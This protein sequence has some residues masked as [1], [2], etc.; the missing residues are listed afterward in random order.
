MHPHGLAY[1][2]ESEGALYADGT[3]GAAKKDDLVP[4]GGIHSYTWRVPERSGP[5]HGDASSVLWMY[6][7]HFV[8]GRDINTGLVGPIVITARGSAKPDGSPKDIDREFVTAFATFDETQSWFFEANLAKQKKTV[9]AGVKPSDPMFRAAFLNYSI[10]GLIEG[11]LPMLTMKEGEHVRWYMF[12]LDND[13]DVHTPHWHGQTAVSNHMRT[14]TIQL[15]PM[16]MAVADM[17]ADNPGTWLFHCHVNE[18]FE[19]GMNARFTVLPS[20]PE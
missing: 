4:P 19:G 13:E 5:E 12:A 11:N 2:K 6:H 16:G 17:I 14:D 7:S 8:E 1:D 15:T 9:P 3:S 18:H 10:N 20:K